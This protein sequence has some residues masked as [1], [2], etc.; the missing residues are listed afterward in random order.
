MQEVHVYLK[1]LPAYDDDDDDDGG[2]GC[3]DLDNAN[4]D[5]SVDEDD[6]DQNLTLRK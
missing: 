3:C 1:Q 2:G 6:E 4:N 5:F